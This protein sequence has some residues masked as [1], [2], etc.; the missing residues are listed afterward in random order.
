MNSRAFVLAVAVVVLGLTVV[1]GSAVMEG[2]SRAVVGI[3]RLDVELAKLELEDTDPDAVQAAA[4]DCADD[5]FGFPM[6]DDPARV[7][8]VYGAM[9]AAERDALK[10]R[11]V[12]CAARRTRGTVAAA[13]E[14]PSGTRVIRAV[15]RSG[16]GS[17]AL[18]AVASAGSCG[19]T[20]VLFGAA[21]AALIGR[22]V[23]AREDEAEHGRV[24]A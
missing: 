12:T 8:A 14:A 7:E 22:R 20:V 16:G 24:G 9:T 18:W 10:D 2:A 6:A 17:T 23:A 15:D 19:L 11:V 13:P 21:G 5:A 4:L 1:F 3:D